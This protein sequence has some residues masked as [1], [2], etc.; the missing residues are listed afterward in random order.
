MGL[1]KLRWYE[2]HF[3]FHNFHPCTYLTS[4]SSILFRNR[5]RV[6]ITAFSAWE[7]TGWLS[8]L[9]IPFQC[10]IDHG[11]RGVVGVKPFLDFFFCFFSCFWQTC[12]VFWPLWQTHKD[13]RGLN[14]STGRFIRTIGDNGRC[15]KLLFNLKHSVDYCGTYSPTGQ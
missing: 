14:I 6:Y 3:C 7:I 8:H 4:K 15:E 10:L 9:L 1:S 12:N 13:T 11:E 2:K 5:L